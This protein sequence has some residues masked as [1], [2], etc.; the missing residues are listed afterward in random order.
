DVQ[1]NRQHRAARIDLALEPPDQCARYG[2]HPAADLLLAESGSLF[3]S[4]AQAA[5]V[6]GGGDNLAASN[7]P[8]LIVLVHAHPSDLPVAEFEAIDADEQLAN[9]GRTFVG[10]VG[11]R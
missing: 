6:S 4:F 7:A 10:R 11:G 3:G 5:A 9:M 2:S 1:R 8:V